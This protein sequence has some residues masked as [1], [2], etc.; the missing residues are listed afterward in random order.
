MHGLKVSVLA[1]FGVWCCATVWATPVAP[2]NVDVR[3]LIT[4]TQFHDTGL[5]TLS[6]QQLTALNAWL[7]QYLATHPAPGSAP[8]DIRNIITVSQFD[9]SGLDKLSPSQIAAFNGW[10]SQYLSAH[11]TAPT[12]PAATRLPAAQAASSGVASFG[13]ETMA[14]AL[15][16]N[17]PE[18]IE[19]RIA[20]RFTGWDGNTIF[21]LENGQVWQQAGT[22]YFTNVT[23][24]DPRVVIKK[25]RFGYLLTLPGHGETVFVRRIK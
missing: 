2:Q 23:L 18:H 17:M 24:D 13:A 12:V 10:L 1:L 14:P 5:D 19:T 4:V 25:L 6:T 22:G 3:N 11:T 16:Q 15:N 8:V 7:A 9:Q 20:G 21:K